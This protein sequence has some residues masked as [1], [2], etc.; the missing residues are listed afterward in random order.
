MSGWGQRRQSLEES[1]EIYWLKPN[2][3]L[4]KAFNK[5]SVSNMWPSEVLGSDLQHLHTAA[6]DP[7]V[8]LLLSSDF[9]L[10]KCL[11][12]CSG[13][14]AVDTTVWSKPHVMRRRDITHSPFCLQILILILHN[15]VCVSIQL[16]WDLS[17]RR[18]VI[19]YTGNMV[20][21]LQQN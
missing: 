13:L 5:S 20:F 17:Q 16:L 4:Y 3:I 21:T 11:R 15:S 6:L 12:A 1:H 7:Q 9:V 19:N 2:Q 8:G 18:W 14:Q 10:Y